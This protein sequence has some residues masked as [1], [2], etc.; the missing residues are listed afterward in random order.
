MNI[1]VVIHGADVIDTGFAVKTLE[2]LREFGRVTARIGG[3][4]G[5]TAIIDHALE[6]MIE[7]TQRERPT[8]ALQRMLDEDFDLVCLLNQ[9]KSLES[10]IRFAE[11]ILDRITTHSTPLIL[12]EAAGAI[13]CYGCGRVE[14][15]LT[16]LLSQKLSLSLHIFKLEHT[17]TRR[18][19]VVIRRVGGVQPGELIH[20]NGI[21]IGRATQREVVI[22]TENNN[23][24]SIRGCE[25]KPHGLEKLR[26]VELET[27]IIRGGAPRE[28]AIAA[29]RQVPCEKQGIAVLIDHDAESSFEK[30]GGA[31]VAV[32]IGDD[33]TA[34]AGDILYRFNIPIIG[35]TDWDRDGLL[36]HTHITDGS[37]IIQVSP[38]FD[39]ILG[40]RVREEVFRG[41]ERIRCDSLES[42]KAQII[43]LL[44]DEIIR[45]HTTPSR[46]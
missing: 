9:G 10:G 15:E 17:L 42:L 33:T 14:Q 7:I 41:A 12:I 45:I 23:I 31:S 19:G 26:E 32:T 28:K 25:I 35:I 24:T 37:I 34:I 30:A 38:G 2:A 22:T 44:G 11:L 39:D 5:R 36:R 40:A 6:D 20:I 43:A 16:E 13:G 21:V 29:P 46:R 18:G 1:G 27:A 8:Q 4:M 3:T